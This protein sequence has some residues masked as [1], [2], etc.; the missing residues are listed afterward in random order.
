MDYELTDKIRSSVV[1]TSEGLNRN[2]LFKKSA[3]KLFARA[4]FSQLN[5]QNHVRKMNPLEVILGF[6]NDL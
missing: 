2:F 6:W 5:S 4:T 3:G 1:W